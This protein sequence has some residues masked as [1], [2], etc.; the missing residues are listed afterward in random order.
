MKIRYCIFI[1]VSLL[2]S[3]LFCH[4]SPSYFLHSS[5]IISL[6][7]APFSVVF[8]GLTPLHSIAGG[9]FALFL[10]QTKNLP[11]KEEVNENFNCYCPCHFFWNPT[12]FKHQTKNPKQSNPDV[13][14]PKF[15]YFPNIYSQPISTPNFFTPQTITFQNSILPNVSPPTDHTPMS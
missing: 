6:I 1:L 5:L 14:Q 2:A 12:S 11:T 10:T 7:L 3:I 15:V 9:F 8:L 13:S 4:V